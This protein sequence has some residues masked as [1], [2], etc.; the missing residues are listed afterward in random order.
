MVLTQSEKRK[1]KN[2]YKIEFFKTG[3][4]EG[5]EGSY[6]SFAAVITGGKEPRKPVVKLF[7]DEIAASA[8]AKVS[9]NCPY[10]RIKLALP[11]SLSGSTDVKV[12]RD[13]IPSRYR[14]IQQPGLCPHLL[15]L[16]ELILSDSTELDRVRKASRQTS[17]SDKLKRLT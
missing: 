9:C 5:Y 7:S 11:L 10:F 17:I 2:Q 14:G 6:M 13:D 4:S 16:V 1:W 8:P 3:S 15:K 12:R